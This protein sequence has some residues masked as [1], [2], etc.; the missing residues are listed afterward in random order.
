MIKHL[1]VFILMALFI[2]TMMMAQNRVVHK[3]PLKIDKQ[4]E[5]STSTRISPPAVD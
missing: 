3:A 2:P 4:N 1:S 5:Y